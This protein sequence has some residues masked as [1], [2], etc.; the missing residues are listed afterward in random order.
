MTVQQALAAV[1][2]WMA[3]EGRRTGRREIYLTSAHDLGTSA[4]VVM[5]AATPPQITHVDALVAAAVAQAEATHLLVRLSNPQWP[6]L[7]FAWE[8]LLPEGQA[9]GEQDGALQTAL[10]SVIAWIQ[11]EVAVT[12]NQ[13]VSV[14]SHLS[15]AHDAGVAAAGGL[16]NGDQ[17]YYAVFLG[18]HR[19]QIHLRGNPQWPNTVG[20]ELRV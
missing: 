13:W 19:G 18:V 15:L 9:Q 8:R 11:N 12:G 20:V 17:A 7:N 4:H 1:L 3:Q 10:Q 5:S 6:T 14:H 2:A 16:T